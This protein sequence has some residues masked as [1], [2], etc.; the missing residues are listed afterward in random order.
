M[1]IPVSIIIPYFCREPCGWGEQAA[2][3]STAKATFPLPPS[4]WEEE[5]VVVRRR[6]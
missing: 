5:W 4:P 6:S 3:C 2:R 1:L